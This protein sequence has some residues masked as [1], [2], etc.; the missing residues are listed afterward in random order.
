MVSPQVSSVL[1]VLS[2]GW[3]ITQLYAFHRYWHAN[4]RSWDAA[5]AL[6]SSDVCTQ[7]NLRVQLRQFDQCHNAEETVSISPLYRAFFQ[8]GEDVHLC[9]N[10]RCE[11]LYL[12][13]TS[14][15][16]PILGLL[17]ALSLCLLC[18]CYRDARYDA[19]LREG[20]QWSLPRLKYKDD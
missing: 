18:K 6:L 10:G 1:S 4:T 16:V 8:V 19:F 13:I 9:G 17:T 5:S 2:A 14:R 12:D 7:P 3:I 20:E 11:L 15:L